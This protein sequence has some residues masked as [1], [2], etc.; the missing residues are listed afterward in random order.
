VPEHIFFDLD[1]TLWDF[2]ANSREALSDLYTEFNLAEKKVDLS[3]FISQYEYQNERC[4]ARYRENKMRKA[5]LNYQ[6][7]YLT[8][9]DFGL[10]DRWLARQMG[11]AYLE[12]SPQKLK[13]IPNA[14][15]VLNAL[16]GKAN[17][18]II[19]N[20]FQE[21]QHQKIQRTGLS[22]FFQQVITSER[23]SAKKPSARIF[24]LA[25][26]LTDAQPNN[27]LMIGDDLNT[28]IEGA[29]QVGWKTIWF[30]RKNQEFNQNAIPKDTRVINSLLSIPNLIKNI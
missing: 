24:N 25:M 8:L 28:D 18:H 9:S 27:C 7:F 2:T 23:A 5:Y 29:S 4:W 10:Q 16:S 17:L 19:T 30:N 22:P 26:K 21:I 14:I 20:G 15:D 3:G 12:L 1:H 6:R 11:R 13:L